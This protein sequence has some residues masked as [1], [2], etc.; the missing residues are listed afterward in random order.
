MAAVANLQSAEPKQWG[1]RR[2]M[3]CPNTGHHYFVV[4]LDDEK[5]NSDTSFSEKYKGDFIGGRIKWQTHSD[6][7]WIRFRPSQYRKP[8]D[9]NSYCCFLVCVDTNIGDNARGTKLFEMS[10]DMGSGG[11]GNQYSPYAYQTMQVDKG[12]KTLSI[13]IDGDDAPSIWLDIEWIA[14]SNEVVYVDLLVDFGNT[15][16]ASALLERPNLHAAF[17]MDTIKGAIFPV[18]FVARDEKASIGDSMPE[19]I[20]DSWFMLS[21]TQFAGVEFCDKAGDADNKSVSSLEHLMTM[22]NDMRLLV[23]ESVTLED[24]INGKKLYRIPQLFVELAPLMVGKSARAALDTYAADLTNEPIIRSSPKRYSWDDQPQRVNWAMVKNTWNMGND[25]KKSQELQ[26]NVLRFMHADSGDWTDGKGN[27]VPPNE[28]PVG[29]APLPAPPEAKYPQRDMLTLS[30]LNVIEH[31][32]LLMNVRTRT[33]KPVERRQLSNVRVTYPAGWTFDELEAYKKCWQRAIDIFAINHLE[34][35]KQARPELKMDLDEAVATQLPIVYDSLLNMGNYIKE[36]LGFYGKTGSETAGGENTVRVMT[37]DIGGGTS[38]CAVVEYK[39]GADPLVLEYSVLLRDS[40]QN[41][42]D[43]MVRILIRSVILPILAKSAELTKENELDLFKE[44][45]R[46]E[47]QI[48]GEDIKSK[49]S[50][51]VRNLLIPLSEYILSNLDTKQDEIVCI[52]ASELEKGLEVLDGLWEAMRGES[53]ID[54]TETGVF[55]KQASLISEK[56]KSLL[57][58]AGN[59]K[60]GG[61]PE[62]SR[63]LVVTEIQNVMRKSMEFLATYVRLLDVDLVILSGKPSELECVQELVSDYVPLPASRCIRAKGRRIG[64]WYPFAR[65]GRIADAKNVNLVGLALHSLT[66]ADLMDGIRLVQAEDGNIGSRYDNEWFVKSTGIPDQKLEFDIYGK[67]RP[68]RM[69]GKDRIYRRL[70]GST[71]GT[72]VYQLLIRNTKADNKEMTAGSAAPERF[73][74]TVKLSRP[75]KLEKLESVSILM[76]DGRQ[77][78]AG[79]RAELKLVMLD[80]TSNTYW[81]DSPNFDF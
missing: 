56:L 76:A 80:D 72:P 49:T 50:F 24:D 46:G 26:G 51:L 34:D 71:V 3:L 11:N 5:Q 29:D 52:E 13:G 69:R 12:P 55:K 77:L 68:V 47:I 16:T 14:N 8:H 23:S 15:R 36:W 74:V 35:W 63:D 33:K 18:H 66:H 75:E 39:G 58:Q 30:A 2:A 21:E 81:I 25:N 28:M 1:R 32:Y 65:Q 61:K 70:K 27:E 37:F 9:E 73:Q 19:A 78:D 54:V 60:E 67:S 59:E 38:D 53:G 43:E 41:A 79:R 45:W 48:K 17:R 7:P 31:A 57:T 64:G 40:T 62:A 6:Y 42:G 4:P 20:V 22:S 10:S 44:L